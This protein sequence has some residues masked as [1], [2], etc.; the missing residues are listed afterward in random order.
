MSIVRVIGSRFL[1]LGALTLGVC[2]VDCTS[3]LPPASIHTAASPNAPFGRYRTFSFEAP[4]GAPEGYTLTA[5]S[6]E[7]QQKMRPLVARALLDKGYV[8]VAEG[9]D[10]IVTHGAGRRDAVGTRQLSRRAVALMGENEQERAFLE[11][12]LVI[13][14]YDRATHDQVWHGAATAEINTSGINEARLADTVGRI[15]AEFP[16]ALH[17]PR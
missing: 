7:V 10:F 9:A 4:M 3:D 16:P 13:D 2:V 12:S 11:G 15:M 1:I 6:I 5:R 14:V 8:E 17:R